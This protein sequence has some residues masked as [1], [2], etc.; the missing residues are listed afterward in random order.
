MQEEEI[1]VGYGDGRFRFKGM[2]AIHL[3]QVIIFLVCFGGISLQMW[4]M[5]VLASERASDVSRREE[6]IRKMLL[7]ALG[8]QDK[9]L[10]QIVAG[11]KT[12]EVAIKESS[13]AQIYVLS[14][15]QNRREALNLQM[16]K[17]VRDRTTR[18]ASRE[19]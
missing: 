9:I 11:N 8:N 13:D 3:F 18:R 10:T 15:P 6:E 2:T 12:V 7:S 19:D 17:S 5:N 16:P 1:S 14:L 4:Q